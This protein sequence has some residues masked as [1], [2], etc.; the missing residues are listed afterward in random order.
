MTQKCFIIAEAGVNHNGSIEMAL[1]LVDVAAHAGADAVKFQTFKAEQ[2]ARPGANKAEYQ[3]RDGGESE[4]QLAML[5][6]LELQ[7]SAYPKLIERCNSLG[8]EFL[9]TPFDKNSANFLTALGMRKIKV[10]S[11]EITNLPFL[12]YLADLRLPIILSTGMATLEEVG[13]AVEIIK[14]TWLKFDIKPEDHLTL[15]HCTSN[16]PAQLHD[17]NLRA[18][19]TM[20]EKFNLSTGYSDHTLGITVSVAAVALGAK[21]IEKHFTLDCSLEGP[22]HRASLDPFELTNMVDQ[23]R[24]VELAL[25]NGDKIPSKNELP[26]RDVARRS[27]TLTQAVLA[28]E[29]ITAEMLSLM[30]PGTGVA[31]KYFNDI[32]GMKS[33][34]DLP[35][36]TTLTWGDVSS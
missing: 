19:A 12:K 27:L 30:R 21:I 1:E 23:I 7:E 31:P 26:I 15:L 24:S 22:D 11:G 28:G 29:E 13:E 33:T 3:H 18:M 4:D 2:L 34:R 6:R 16:Y 35:A 9:S 20:N 32:V 14:S 25:G 36:W 10:P 17:V 8:I 5:K